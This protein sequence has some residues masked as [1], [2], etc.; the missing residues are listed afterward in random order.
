MV[1]DVLCPFSSKFANLRAVRGLI[2]SHTQPF[3]ITRQRREDARVRKRWN[4]VVEVNGRRGDIVSSVS[5]L[6]EPDNSPVGGVLIHQR[7]HGQNGRSGQRVGG[8]ASATV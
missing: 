1:G 2:L 3:S 8:V 4:S 6:H 7:P 5:R